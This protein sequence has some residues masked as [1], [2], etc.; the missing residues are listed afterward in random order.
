MNIKILI[1]LLLVTVFIVLYLILSDREHFQTT[2]VG[3]YSKQELNNMY[4]DLENAEMKCRELDERQR[5]DSELEQIRL[6][7]STFN[8]LEELDKKIDELTRIVKSLKIEKKKQDINNNKCRNN[9]QVKLNEQYNILNKLAKDG[10]VKDRQLKLDLNVSDGLKESLSNL[11]QTESKPSRQ[12]KPPSPKPKPKCKKNTNRD[13]INLTKNKE[14][15]KSKCHRCDT[16]ALEKQHDY[17]L[18][19]FK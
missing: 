8:E 14:L 11:R 17:L 16:D 18:R 6:N 4:Q 10:L 5:L 3:R 9:E 7:E 13:Y 19:D 12:I 15:I 2:E 1:I